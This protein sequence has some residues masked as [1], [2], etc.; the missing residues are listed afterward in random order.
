MTL[1]VSGLLISHEWREPCLGIGNYEYPHEARMEVSSYDL[2]HGI[3]QTGVGVRAGVRGGVRAGVRGSE[4]EWESEGWADLNRYINY[5]TAFNSMGQAMHL[6]T[7]L[8]KYTTYSW[9]FCA[10]G[11]RWR[12]CV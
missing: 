10:I 9:D 4:A 7:S 12:Y 11:C 2:L 8:A 1:C 3:Y 5:Y 6:P